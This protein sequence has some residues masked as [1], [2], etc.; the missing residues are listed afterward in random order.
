MRKARHRRQATTSSQ[1][2]MAAKFGS[3]SPDSG[4]PQTP[5]HCCLS[6]LIEDIRTDLTFANKNCNVPAVP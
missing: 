6:Q 1:F 2:V 3:D 4:F 5:R